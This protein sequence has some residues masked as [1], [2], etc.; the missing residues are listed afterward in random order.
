MERFHTVQEGDTL[1]AIG[2]AYGVPWETIQQA[3]GI[4]DADKINPNQIFVIPDPDWTPPLPDRKPSLDAFVTSLPKFEVPEEE[5][6]PLTQG[7][8]TSFPQQARQPGEGPEGGFDLF[9]IIRSA[10][11]G[12][13]DLEQDKKIAEHLLDL[14][15]YPGQVMSG[16]KDLYDPET[17]ELSQEATDKA[18]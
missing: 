15:K 13:V 2:K 5:K 7:K 4:E 10:T 3:N 12:L 6:T 11:G 8:E 16:E 9:E 18:S 1:S 14:A 17:G